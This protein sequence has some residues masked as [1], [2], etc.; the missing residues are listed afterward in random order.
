MK[1][2]ILI[3]ILTL[4]A[5]AQALPDYTVGTGGSWLRGATYPLNNDTSFAI[6]LGTS[7]WFSWTDIVTPIVKAPTG[8]A[9]VPSTITTGAT[10]LLAC[11]GSYSVCLMVT[12]LGG[13]AAAGGGTAVA[14]AFT[15]QLGAWFRIGQHIYI[16]PQAKVSNAAYSPTSGALATAVF[17]P[18]VQIS[19]G[20]TK[21]ASP[22]AQAAAKPATAKMIRKVY[23]WAHLSAPDETAK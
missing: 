6:R 22:A 7:N 1:R 17:S 13:V 5:F 21:G 14:P 15:G 2:L 12:A 8:A 20:F 11:N 19:Y 18:E 4:A 10:Y 3:P 9:P 16:T 23:R